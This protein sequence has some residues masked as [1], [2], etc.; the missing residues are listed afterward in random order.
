MNS[1]LRDALV[2]GVTWLDARL[3]LD[4]LHPLVLA[5]IMDTLP[6]TP[7]SKVLDVGCGRGWACR[8]MARNGAGEVVGVD[9]DALSLVRAQR[10]TPTPRCGVDDGS[11]V[12]CRADAAALPFADNYFDLAVASFSFSW[13]KEP[14]RAVKEIQ[15]VLQTGGQVYI[16]DVYNRGLGALFTRCSNLLMGSKERLYSAAQFRNLLSPYFSRIQQRFLGPLGWGLLTTGV[17]E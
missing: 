14:V 3:E 11:L 15:R 5:P 8:R 16:I 13:W 1:G 4:V 17:K 6:L 9:I 12:Y 10:R 7:G 2:R